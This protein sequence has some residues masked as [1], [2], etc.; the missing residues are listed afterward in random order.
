MNNLPTKP[1]SSIEMAELYRGI[2]Q[3]SIRSCMTTL[4]MVS[5]YGIGNELKGVVDLALMELKNNP[6]QGFNFESYFAM[7]T[8]LDQSEAQM[9]D[10]Y[11]R[12][13]SQN[14]IEATK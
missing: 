1:L 10:R 11:Y 8:M 7:Q 9:I 2:L 12:I 6:A 5:R 13:Q 3:D 14:T 4:R